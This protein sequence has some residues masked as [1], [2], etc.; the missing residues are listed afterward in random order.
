MEW[1]YTESYGS[2]PNK[3]REPERLRRYENIV[4][5]PRGPIRAEPSIALTDLFWEPI[6]QLFRQQ[7][8]A[9]RMQAAKEEG[10]ERVRVLHISPA[11]NLALRR[12]TSPNLRKHGGDVFAVFASLLANADDFISRSTET[13]FAPLVADAA[14]N[15]EWATYLRS[16]YTFMTDAIRI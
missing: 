16:R 5:A 4:F 3:K 6:Y 13:L 9:H 1:K 2:P 11:A 8:L 7:I 15:D 10:A 14:D 12:I